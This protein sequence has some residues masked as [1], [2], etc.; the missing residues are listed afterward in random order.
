MTLYNIQKTY[1]ILIENIQIFNKLLDKNDN[2]N[3]IFEKEKNTQEIGNSFYITDYTNILEEY[4]D[5][6]VVD[7]RKRIEIIEC[8]SYEHLVKKNVFQQGQKVN[9][10]ETFVISSTIMDIIKSIYKDRAKP[11]NSTQYKDFEYIIKQY[12]DYFEK[13]YLLRSDNKELKEKIETFGIKLEDIYL[14]ILKSIESLE[15]ETTHNFK[16]NED[17]KD[18]KI[19]KDNYNKAK[20][21]Q[22]KYIIPL[23]RFT[24]EKSSD[25]MYMIKYIRDFLEKEHK[26]LGLTSRLEHFYIQFLYVIDKIKPIKNYMNNYIKQSK[27][28][29]DRNLGNEYLFNQ[30]T[31]MISENSIGG[32]R[33]NKIWNFLNKQKI[34]FF[35]KNKA[36]NHKEQQIKK[37]NINEYFLNKSIEVINENIKERSNVKIE[38]EYINKEYEKLKEEARKKEERRK[39]EIIFIN[40]FNLYLQ[41]QPLN[42]D[43]EVVTYIETFFKQNIKLKDNWIIGDLQYLTNE[44]IKNNKVILKSTYKELVRENKKT[45][46]KVIIKG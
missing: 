33:N 13:N 10:I 21:L 36:E 25:F 17:K 44:Y 32:M 46:Y 37:H 6:E 43:E 1:L 42:K 24:N 19:V 30:L 38:K 28:N 40:E 22:D 35:F 5:K 39:F 34:D 29:L 2:F 12:K 11:L 14:Q 20:D 8:L 41:R 45:K 7:K 27:L 3:N 16:S 23:Y 26:L 9:G 4:V 31:N 15:Y 18:I